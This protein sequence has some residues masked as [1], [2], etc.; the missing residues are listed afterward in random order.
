VL[1]LAAP[2]V[3]G[4][5]TVARAG[6]PPSIAL[7][8]DVQVADLGTFDRI[9]FVFQ[10]GMPEVLD[11]SYFTGPAIES[12]SGEPLAPPLLGDA[13]FTVTMGN[14]SG[15]DLSGPT[16]VQIYTG[17]DR[18]QP[19]LPSVVDLALTEDFEA[20]LQWTI[21]LRHGEVASEVQVLS[22]P[23]RVVV[24]IPHTA[25][26]PIVAQPTFTG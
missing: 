2:L 25:P 21:G 17:P 1:A 14:A 7:L 15:V 20:T 19:D 16:F 11:A 4:A 12:P 5:F 24:D 9:T 8:N 10:G 26:R 13:R 23:T 6:T 18:I 3:A 22:S